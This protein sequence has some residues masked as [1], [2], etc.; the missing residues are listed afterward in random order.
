MV[1]GYMAPFDDQGTQAGAVVVRLL[2]GT[3]PTAI[4]QSKFVNVPVVDWRALRR[5]RI[6]ENL[7]PAIADVRLREPT[8]WEKYWRP[9][10]AGIALLLLQAGLIT[11]L[12]A[13][14]RSRART[15]TALEESQRQ[16]SLA[17][18]AAQLSMWVWDTAR[19]RL[20]TMARPREQA[21]ALHDVV[22]SMHPNDRE[23]FERSVGM[24]L[25]TGNEFDVEYRAVAADGDVRWIAARGRAAKDDPHRLLG[26]AVD[27]TERKLAELRAVEDRVALRHMTRV[28]MLGQL[29][30]SIAHQ[31]NQPLAAILGNA[32]AARKMLSREP[33]DLAELREIC[34]DIVTED[35]RAAE[36]IRR[37]G[38]LYKR[39]EMKMEP[40]DLNELIRETLDLLRAELLTRH[41]V[42]RVELAPELPM[43]D[44]GR[45]QLQQVV[46]NLTLNA[47]DA[48]N[49]I[50]VEAR[51][52]TIRSESTGADVRVSVVDNGAGIAA[53]DLKH[54]FDA[55]W[56]TKP[57][58]MGIGLAI[59]Q[60]IVAA[61]HGR[62]TAAN[63]A[64]GGATFCVSLP[65]RHTT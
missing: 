53:D 18:N 57:G 52:V 36:V 13:E 37:L 46:L 1:G 16:M 62:I 19:G 32:E 31:L 64:E 2:N 54:V 65:V 17:A 55:F 39:G 40:L 24:A 8:A 27:I 50:D 59:C 45:V 21:V 63:N 23:G 15:A 26:V 33:V 47:A 48:M 35:N 20:E 4:A 44:G 28:S 6:D 30:A 43:I 7:L 5:W 9:I 25:A 12:L 58:G 49:G 60:S 41:I 22:A 11:A 3:P 51:T 56:I 10:S 34:D 29:S 42:P 61:H 14:R 38:A